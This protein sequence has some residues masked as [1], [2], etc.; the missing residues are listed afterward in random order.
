MVTCCPSHTLSKAPTG[1]EMCGEH[2]SAPPAAGELEQQP[3]PE[4][5]LSLSFPSC[6]MDW[7]RWPP[8]LLPAPQ[9]MRV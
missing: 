4:A 1:T 9:F 5:A 7:L 3:S 8:K 6:K 2:V